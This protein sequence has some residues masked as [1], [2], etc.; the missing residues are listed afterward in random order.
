MGCSA[1]RL[2]FQRLALVPPAQLGP[3]Y[4]AIPPAR[5]LGGTDAGETN[6]RGPAARTR[7]KIDPSLGLVKDNR[8]A[9]QQAGLRPVEADHSGV[10][11]PGRVSREHLLWPGGRS[12]RGKRVFREAW[13]PMVT[14]RSGPPAPALPCFRARH[15][16]RP[17]A[18]SHRLNASPQFLG[19]PPAS[20]GPVLLRCDRL[21]MDF[22]R[23]RI[24]LTRG[25]LSAIIPLRRFES[26]AC[27]R[28]TNAAKAN[29]KGAC[30]GA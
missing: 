26:P 15:A 2:Q 9:R 23:Q 5:S 1:P 19:L 14:D 21:R 13:I 3:P 10:G 6:R 17:C 16:L 28:V 22:S 7:R 27:G 8:Q 25:P 29:P 18:T 11:R 30:F 12:P 24:A 4:R 20:V